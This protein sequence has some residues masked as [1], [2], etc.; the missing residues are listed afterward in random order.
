MLKGSI[1]KGIAVLLIITISY[2]QFLHIFHTFLHDH[3]QVAYRETSCGIH[4]DT[5]A[6]GTTH[7]SQPDVRL[8]LYEDPCPLCD[9]LYHRHIVQFSGSNPVELQQYLPKSV[10]LGCQEKTFVDDTCAQLL[11]NKGPPLLPSRPA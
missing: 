6:G 8:R 4:D 1:N 11:F 5:R 10:K 9:D 2:T 3:R 7:T